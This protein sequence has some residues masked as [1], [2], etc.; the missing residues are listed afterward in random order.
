MPPV[1]GLPGLQA[2]VVPP[3]APAVPLEAPP[4]AAPPAEAPPLEAPPRPAAPPLAPPP[5]EKPPLEAPPRP[6]PPLEAPPLA[7]PPLEKP[8]LEAPP[9]PAPPLEAPP[10]AAPPAPAPSFTAPPPLALPPFALPPFAL[11]PLA[12]L[13]ALLELLPPG[14]LAPPAEAPVSPVSPAPPMR[15]AS[16][17]PELQLIRPNAIPTPN[18][19][20]SFVRTGYL[21]LGT[22][23]AI[24]ESR[25][26]D[27]ERP[28]LSPARRSRPV[29]RHLRHEP[30]AGAARY[31]S[32][33][34]EFFSVRCH[35]SGVP[36]DVAVDGRLESST[37]SPSTG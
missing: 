23:L 10:L 16:P 17:D 8:P 35:T 22:R 1:P 19:C 25:S 14:A 7:P 21:R 3:P 24:P 36:R 15:G 29:Q 9:R 26:V 28:K 6:A 32:A 12:V 20:S 4:L 13:P 11:P 30:E 34:K 31:P 27:H 18:V 33:K 5:L 2:A 37:A